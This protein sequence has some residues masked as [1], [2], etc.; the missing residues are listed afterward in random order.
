MRT[1]LKNR[2]MYAVRSMEGNFMAQDLANKVNFDGYSGRG[3]TAISV[4]RIA[5]GE[6][7]IT[8]AGK[9]SRTTSQIWRS[10]I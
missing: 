7:F 5:H 10:K 3:V 9:K 6:G 2:I 4:A 8:K 1:T